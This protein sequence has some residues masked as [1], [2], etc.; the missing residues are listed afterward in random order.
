MNSLWIVMSAGPLHIPHTPG[1]RVRVT[2]PGPVRQVSGALVG[3]GYF[4]Y[5]EDV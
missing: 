4:G 5:H 2:S 3:V 1:A